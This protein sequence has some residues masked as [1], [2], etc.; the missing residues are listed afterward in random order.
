MLRVVM[1]NAARADLVEHYVY[2]TEVASEGVAER[3]WQRLE[4]SFTLLAG[5]PHIGLSVPT[6]SPELQG[7]RKWSVADFDRFLIFYLPRPGDILVVRVLH[8]SRDWWQ[9]LGL[10]EQR[11][12][13][14]Q[15]AVKQWPKIADSL[16][17]LAREQ[18]QMA[19]AFVLAG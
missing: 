7:V 12:A 16:H 8:S 17:I 3:L 10:A 4:D 18:A 13:R 2:L 14:S 6:T 9:L 1:S 5:Q 15:A 11:G 19:A